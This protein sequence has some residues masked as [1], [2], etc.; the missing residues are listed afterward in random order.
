MRLAE[1]AMPPCRS[2]RETINSAPARS[3]FA[4]VGNYPREM[5]FL[6]LDIG[7]LWV[8]NSLVRHFIRT[9]D[10]VQAREISEKLGDIH[11]NKLIRA[12]L[13]HTP[14]SEVETLAKESAP[15]DLA[16][17]DAENRFTAAPNYAF[18]GQNDIALKL[19]KSG[20]EGKYCAYD[21]LQTDPLLAKLR[22]MP[23]F[24]AIVAAA[25]KC[26]ADFLAERAQVSRRIRAAF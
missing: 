21:T 7:S 13:N 22:G 15:E 5:D 12:C 10:L 6:Q 26:Q 25:K 20:V 2:T 4:S 14:P 3:L 16:N 23:E 9:G 11:R 1:S 17:A 19:L 24:G 8:S 18:C